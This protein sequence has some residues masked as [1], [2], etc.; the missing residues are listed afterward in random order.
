MGFGKKKGPKPEE[1]YEAVKSNKKA[2]VESLLAAKCDPNAFKD[3]FVRAGLF[4]NRASSHTSLA[5][6]PVSA[7]PPL[8]SPQRAS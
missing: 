6:S 8:C 1:I 2:D 7:Q 4:S 5:P 3:Q